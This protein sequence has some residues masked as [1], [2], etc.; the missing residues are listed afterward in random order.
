MTSIDI[1]YMR[2]ALELARLGRGFTAPNPLV[3]CVIVHEGRIIGEGW[4][5]Q[6]GGPHAEV[7]ALESVKEKHLLPESRLYVTLEPCSHYGKT[8]PCADLLL[9]NQIADVVI[10]N[11]DPN[12]LVQGRGIRKLLEANCK[13][14]VGLLEK[15]GLALNKYFFTFHQRKRPY[16]TLKWA[17]TADGFIGRQDAEK[18]QISGELS[19]MLTHQWRSEQ[20]AIM[21]G[22]RTAAVDNPQ[23]NTRA[24]T[25]PDPLRIILD[26]Q[27]SLPG[28]LKVFDQ[29]QPTLVYNVQ[30]GEATPRL[31]WVKLP[32]EPDL[33]PAVLA[34]L[35]ARNIQS[36]LVEGGAVLLNSFL[37]AGLWDEAHVFKSSRKLEAAGIP[38]PTLPLSQMQQVSHL[39]ADVLIT[40]K[41]V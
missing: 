32:A 20:Q 25:G 38:A 19:R 33:L 21:V 18:C 29:S 28:N 5:R 24:W 15:E 39:G 26:R 40:Y 6:Y 10:C 36:V 22:T 37:Q 27:L 7:N 1:L 13:V 3:G 9:E 11:T 35:H 23:L 41:N 34:D 30:K 4:H 17:E 8:P 14:H 2:R 31:E 16:I 12:P